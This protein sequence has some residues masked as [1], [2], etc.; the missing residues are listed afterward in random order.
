MNKNTG[1]GYI[2]ETYTQRKQQARY[3][4]ILRWRQQEV[5]KEK[6][7]HIKDLPVKTHLQ[8]SETSKILMKQNNR[9]KWIKY[10]KISCWL[11]V[12]HKKIPWAYNHFNRINK[13]FTF[14]KANWY[15]LPNLNVHLGSCQRQAQKKNKI[16][17]ILKRWEDNRTRTWWWLLIIL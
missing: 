14:L 5:K 10:S 3:R 2:L 7:K 8:S 9:Q 1:S 16:C 13:S 6:R 15:L 12:I 4:M 17:S 11:R